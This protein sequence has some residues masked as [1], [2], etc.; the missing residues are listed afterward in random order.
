MLFNRLVQRGENRRGCGL[1]QAVSFAQL[2]LDFGAQLLLLLFQNAVVVEF[3]SN[4]GNLLVIRNRWK[5]GLRF[6]GRQPGFL[7]TA[8]PGFLLSLMLVSSV[9]NIFDGAG[10]LERPLD[11]IGSFLKLLSCNLAFVVR[12]QGCLLLRCLLLTT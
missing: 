9:L 6:N 8:L 7:I 11:L 2:L 4:S 12:C 3:A 5:Q 10:L 1:Q